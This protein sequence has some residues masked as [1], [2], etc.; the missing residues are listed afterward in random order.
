MI[1]RRR[2]REKA[3]DAAL[4]PASISGHLAA[5]TPREGGYPLRRREISGLTPNGT[6]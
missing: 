6:A 1:L 3:V 5:E 2:R 4:V